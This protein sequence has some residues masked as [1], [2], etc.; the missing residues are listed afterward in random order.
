MYLFRQ[1]SVLIA[2]E[3]QRE[4]KTTFLDY[5]LKTLFFS[6]QELIVDLTGHKGAAKR[7]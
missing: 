2:V 5:F 3:A 7:V 6:P 4:D 1:K